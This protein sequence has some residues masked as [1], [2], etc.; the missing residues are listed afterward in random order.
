MA[1]FPFMRNRIRRRFRWYGKR[2]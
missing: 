1:A 2:Q